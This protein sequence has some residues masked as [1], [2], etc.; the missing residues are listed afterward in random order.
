MLEVGAWENAENKSKT[1]V[2]CIPISIV[3]PF[4]FVFS[5]YIGHDSNV[6][7]DLL[8]FVPF[9]V[10]HASSSGRS[11]TCPTVVTNIDRTVQGSDIIVSDLLLFVSYSDWHA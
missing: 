5:D 4:P 2:K 3:F 10:W 1:A 6:I 11:R 9:S 8:L 7:S